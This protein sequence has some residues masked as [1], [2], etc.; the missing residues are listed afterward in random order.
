MRSAQ[1]EILNPS[2]K[3]TMKYY[4]ILGLFSSSV[5]L[6]YIS[7]LPEIISMVTTNQMHALMVGAGVIAL[8]TMFA[9][10]PATTSLL[11]RRLGLV[12]MVL[13][14]LKQEMDVSLVK[15]YAFDGRL[16]NLIVVVTGANSGTG[17]AISEL[18]Y[19]RG[20]TVVMSCR[21]QSRCQNAA[22]VIEL[23]AAE[24]G[25]T[26]VPVGRLDV[27]ILD[28]ADLNSVRSFADDMKRNYKR[29]DVLV[30]N[31]GLA[32]KRGEKTAQGLEM[33]FGAMHVGH[34]ALTNWLLPLL[35]NPIQQ[36]DAESVQVSVPPLE[37]ARIVNIGSQ[38]YVSG[39]FHE[40]LFDSA[41]DGDLQGEIT[42]NCRTTG[43]FGAIPCCPVLLCPITN[44]Y[45]RAKLANLLH[46]QELQRIV[47]K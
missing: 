10:P 27:K 47:G 34:F 33:A 20:A 22:K 8:A 38:A 31:A 15:R 6:F 18:L 36:I 19:Q 1:M 28:L 32:S 24:K 23:S 2:T 43:P 40:S 13:Y 30:N 5:A 25:S 3:P 9:M 37:S 14:Q 39:K 45:A 4:F 26:A 11:V 12:F 46:G 35:S 44:G 17:R 16:E 21:S 7:R 41:G 29:I 42:D